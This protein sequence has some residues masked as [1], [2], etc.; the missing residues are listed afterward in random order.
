MNVRTLELRD[1]SVTLE[2]DSNG[3]NNWTFGNP[4]APKPPPEDS[5]AGLKKL[6]VAF[7][8]AALSNLR[9][10]YR[11]PGHKDQVA[12]VESLTVLP[13]SDDMLAVEG[14]GSL[15]TYAATLSGELG[16]LHAL[17]SGRDIR[18]SIQA[19]IGNLQVTAKGAVGRLYPLAGADLNL[20]ADNPDLGTMLQNLGVPEFADG[21]MHIVASLKPAGQR[22]QVELQGT[23]GDITTSIGGT[24][25][26]L[27]LRDSNLDF[28][29]EALDAARLAAAFDLKSVPA[30]KLEITGRL[31]TSSTEL[32]FE[33][34]T[35]KLGGT[36]P[37]STRL[38]RCR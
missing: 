33:G 3:G 14:K 6:P 36:R 10:T 31:A 20:T 8:H 25:A 38:V 37:G 24:I 29:L 32:K 9:V 12:Q 7:Q 18:M 11:V 27:G 23:A 16:P 19:S 30:V 5:D 15:D 35:V 22:T 34:V 13:G 28:S 4:N 1:V 17:L 26:E 2:R 21:P